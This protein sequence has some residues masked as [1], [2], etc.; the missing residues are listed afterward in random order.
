M[1]FQKHSCI[2]HIG[3][4]NHTN[5]LNEENRGKQCIVNQEGSYDC[6]T[7]MQT[8]R[9]HGSHM[10][11]ERAIPRAEERRG[12]A[13][14]IKTQKVRGRA[15]RGWLHISDHEGNGEETAHLKLMSLSRE[16]G[17][18]RAKTSSLKKGRV[19]LSL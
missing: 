11:A 4:R 2:N 5:Y 18:S 7:K 15:Y 1:G 16:E 10:M 19:K 13:E 6:K 14:T 12:Q 17:L 8:P 9:Y 3:V